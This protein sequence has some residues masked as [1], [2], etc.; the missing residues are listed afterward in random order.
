MNRKELTPRRQYEVAYCIYRLYGEQG[1][2]GMEMDI[3]S[4]I[5]HCA[6]ISYENRNSVF[7]GWINDGNMDF[8]RDVAPY[9]PEWDGIPF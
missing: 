1:V 6:F 4:E 5:G 9:R 7:D 2:D 8:F 3:T